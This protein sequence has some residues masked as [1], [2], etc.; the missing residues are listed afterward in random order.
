MKK[1]FPGSGWVAMFLFLTG[2]VLMLSPR[3]AAHS[4]IP[5][6][7]MLLGNIIYTSDMILI[8]QRAWVALG[9]FYAVWDVLLIFA[10]WYDIEILEFVKPITTILERLI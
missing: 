6:V 2:T 1:S 5:W 4:T 10:R 8:K 7:F 9:L 3:I